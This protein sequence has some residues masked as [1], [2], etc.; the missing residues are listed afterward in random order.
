MITYSTN[1]MGPI[2]IDWYRKRG[3][4]QMVNRPVKSK[5]LS[6]KLKLR[7]GEMYEREEITTEYSCGRID[8][9]GLDENEHYNGWSEYSL[10]MMRSDDW[11][12]FS[13]WLMEFSSEKLVEKEKLIEMFEEHRNKKIRWWNDDILGD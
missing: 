8:I 9:R 13:Q 4:T 12:E 6:K 2:N 10:G 7:I 5:W 1:W 3:L 11:S